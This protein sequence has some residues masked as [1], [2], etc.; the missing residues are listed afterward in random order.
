M[1]PEATPATAWLGSDVQ[2]EV[3]VPEAVQSRGCCVRH[4]GR[5][6]E[7]LRK[8]LVVVLF[9]YIIYTVL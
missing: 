7:I 2:P 5:S 4:T 8:A 3:S 9:L 6:N 1:S